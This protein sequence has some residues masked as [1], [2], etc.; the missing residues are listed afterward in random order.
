M[1]KRTKQKVNNEALTESQ[2]NTGG[3][4]TIYYVIPN[5]V[6]NKAFLESVEKTNEG[7]NSHV[8]KFLIVC[9]HL[10]SVQQT[11][12]LSDVLRYAK[13]FDLPVHETTSLF[14]RWIQKMIDLRKAEEVMN[15]VYDEPLYILI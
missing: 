15:T 3:L 13:P 4:R 11:V 6:A 7:A 10:Q 12:C 14:H 5:E 1:A 9:K 8:E 2:A